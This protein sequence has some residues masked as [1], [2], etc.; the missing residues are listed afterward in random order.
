MIAI[1]YWSSAI[2]VLWTIS[3]MLVAGACFTVYI[4]SSPNH[5]FDAKVAFVSL[6][7]F[8]L[9]RFP[10]GILPSVL[11]RCVRANVSAKRI[12]KFLCTEEIDSHRDINN[13]NFDSY[14]NENAVVIENANFAW[15]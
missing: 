4:L 7:V 14:L 11:S 15:N 13:E 9:L 1:A 8:N 12:Q 10:M 6:S 3:P 5:V 2:D